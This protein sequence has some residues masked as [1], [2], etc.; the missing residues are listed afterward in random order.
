MTGVLHVRV[1]TPYEAE[2]AE[3]GG[4]DRIV[5]VPDSGRSPTP[6]LAA[7]VRR[8]S[9]VH[10]RV[11]LRL[12]E[13]YTT[14]GGELTRLKGLAFSY[15]DAGADGFVYGFL[16]AM[17]GI[18][19]PA[20]AELAA[21]AWPWTFDR[22]IDAVLDQ[23]RAWT[24]LAALPRVDGALTAGS[25]REVEQG[26]DRLLN[27]PDRA[28]LIAAGA[29]KPEHVPWLVRGGVTQFYVDQAPVTVDLVRAWRRLTDEEMARVRPGTVRP[30]VRRPVRSADSP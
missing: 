18:D 14:D 2:C 27:H 9:T 30:P 8:A 19:K 12:R 29:L 23:T 25:A 16:N 6:E 7:K 15:R 26:I 17:A 1:R 5:L 13:D 24:E 21:E 28:W 20:C 4:A 10:L 3:Q 22:A 11:L